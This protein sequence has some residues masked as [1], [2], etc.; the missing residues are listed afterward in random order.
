VHLPGG[1]FRAG[2]PRAVWV[3]FC[4]PPGKPP[5]GAVLYCVGV[6]A[7]DVRMCTYYEFTTQ[8]SPFC[9]VLT[10]SVC[11]GCGP[12]LLVIRSKSSSFEGCAEAHKAVCSPRAERSGKGGIALLMRREEG[13]V[14]R[15]FDELA[16]GLDTG[17]ISR[18]RAI[19]L[20]GAA[21]VAS[22][23]GLVGAREA[24]AQVSTLGIRRRRCNRR[25]GDFCNN[26]G[27]AVP[28]FTRQCH[29]CCGEGRG[30]RKRRRACCGSAGCNCCRRG[31]RCTSTGRCE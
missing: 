4:Y 25:G 15:S 27:E 29:I 20:A 22:A 14:A 28:P 5:L 8:E 13:G 11:R 2:T 16:T 3:T 19:K 24:D 12:L 9:K 6:L 1:H 23:V 30:R 10:L 7:P 31:E 21:L 17:A 26:K 18:A